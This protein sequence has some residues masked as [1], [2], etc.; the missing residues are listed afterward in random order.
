MPYEY[1]L[2]K[3]KYEQVENGCSVRMGEWFYEI[4]ICLMRRLL[5]YFIL[6]PLGN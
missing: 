2:D 1:F 6:D 5:H 4:D 3:Y